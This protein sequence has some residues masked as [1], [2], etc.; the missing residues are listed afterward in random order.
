MDTYPQIPIFYFVCEIFEC[1]SSAVFPQEGGREE[2]RE[3]GREGET[4]GTMHTS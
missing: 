1:Y 3:G 4:G 2:G